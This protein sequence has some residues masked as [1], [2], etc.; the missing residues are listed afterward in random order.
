MAFA[1]FSRLYFAVL[2]LEIRVLLLVCFRLWL[3]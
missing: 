1:D 2:S 3:V